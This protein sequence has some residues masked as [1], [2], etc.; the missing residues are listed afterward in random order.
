MVAIPACHCT[1]CGVSDFY[2]PLVAYA[3]DR[4]VCGACLASCVDIL[5]AQRQAAEATA[6]EVADTLGWTWDL[7]PEPIP[8]ADDAG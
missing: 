8:V 6:A 7:P 2:A 3:F 1:F 4:Y 5:A